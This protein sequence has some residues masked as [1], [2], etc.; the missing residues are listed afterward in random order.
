MADEDEATARR[1]PWHSVY[2]VLGQELPFDLV[3][4]DLRPQVLQTC[5]DVLGR[6]FL[7]SWPGGPQEMEDSLRRGVEESGAGP[8]AHG[9]RRSQAQEL[10]GRLAP[11]VA[12][13]VSVNRA[14]AEAT[15]RESAQPMRSSLIATLVSAGDGEEIEVVSPQAREK[16]SAGMAEGCVVRI[17]EELDRAKEL[18]GSHW[19]EAMT[20]SLGEVASLVAIRGPSV[21]DVVCPA[22]S[23]RS[24]T[25]NLRCLQPDPSEALYCLDLHDHPLL[26]CGSFPNCHTC[27]A[28]CDRRRI[29]EGYRCPKCDFD[30]CRE[31]AKAYESGVVRSRRHLAPL[32]TAVLPRGLKSSRR[33]CA[34][35][36]L[37]GGCRT[38]DG[39]ATATGAC[40]SGKFFICDACRNFDQLG[41][42]TAETRCRDLEDL[43]NSTERIAV[44]LSLHPSEI[45][46]LAENGFF[47]KLAAHL[48]APAVRTLVLDLGDWLSS[49]LNQVPSGPVLVEVDGVWSESHVYATE[50]SSRCVPKE[51]EENKS[52]EPEIEEPQECWVAVQDERGTANTMLKVPLSSIRPAF[53]SHGRSQSPS[54]NS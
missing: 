38:A 11:F 9:L 40:G 14:A 50:P 49:A 30:V 20:Q 4:E 21:G 5:L 43:R 6:S 37:P 15:V 32:G 28:D 53:V 25:W 29:W 27:D 47:T 23:H 34:G 17:V 39:D 13:Q 16:E 3:F 42:I 48:V 45:F 35:E 31:C 22:I 36:L 33:S 41:E 10:S 18:Q 52:E 54:K 46:A 1:R 2:L 51:S 8:V 44:S 24:Q 12:T 7:R 26:W 19:A